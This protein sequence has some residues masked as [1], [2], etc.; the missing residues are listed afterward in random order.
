MRVEDLET[1]VPVVELPVMERNLQR[2]QDYC[3]RH[4]IKLRPHIKTHKMPELARRQVELG[5][6]GITCQ[7]LGEAEVMADAG[8]DDIFISYPLIG[9]GKAPRLAALAKRVRM[10]VAVDNDLALDT[11]AEA[12]REA[13]TPIGVVVEFDSGNKRTGVET[14]EEALALAKRIAATENLRFDGLMTYPTSAETARFVAEARP[15]FAAEGLEIP[16]VTGG[17]SPGAMRVHEVAPIDEMRVGTY[18]YN[19]RAMLGAGA[20]RLEDVA[21]VVHATVIS[22][23]AEGRAILD[24]GSK[25]LSSDLVAPEVGPGYGLLV[26]YP[27]AVITRVNEEHGTVDVSRCAVKPAIGERVRIIPNHTCVVTNLHDRVV[28]ARDGEVVEQRPV[29]ARGRTT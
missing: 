14:V 11:V 7:K 18:I 10:R 6:V 23:P 8:L 29:A 3:D 13:G 22:R 12:A 1:P 4:G 5:A 16:M 17:G 9:A 25:T 27:D 15:R 20:A 26:D 2:M 24:C 28:F 19:D 21:M